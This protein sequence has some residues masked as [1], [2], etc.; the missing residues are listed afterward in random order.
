MNPSRQWL[1]AAAVLAAPVLAEASLTWEANT[2]RGLS[3]FEGLEQ[4]PGL[5][6]IV[7]DPKGQY[8]QVY[9]YNIWD[10]ADGSKD[11]CESRGHK[12]TDGTNMQLTRGNTYYI[13]WRSLW[14]GNVGTQSGKWVAVWQMHAYGGVGMGA[15]FVFRTLGDGILHLQ[16]NVVGTDIHIWNTPMVRNVWHRF[17]LHTHLDPSASVG[18]VELW[19]DGVQQKF[20]N[21]E[22]RYYCPTHEDDAGT[23][24]KL[25]WGIYRT[26]SAT[27]NWHAWMSRARIGTTFADVDPDGGSGPT[28]TPTATPTATATPRATPTATATPGGLAGYYRITARHSGKAVAVQSAS[29]SD[30]ANVFQWTYG[31]ANT[32]DEWEVRGIGSGYYRVINRNSGKDMVVQSAST[33][34]GANIFQWTYGGSSTNDEWA[35]VDVGGGYFRITNR[36]SGKSA[37]VAGGG[38]TDGTNVD[39]RTYSGATYQQFQLVAV[40]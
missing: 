23:Y 21:G 40:P 15:P 12:L 6:D 29:T 14:D 8:G 39:Q 19:Y 10:N 1:L 4:S 35:I 30:G 27:G 20:I 13:G 26:G 18:W 37:E 2:S 38:T 7:N 3:V 34:D 17:V 25:K 28:P 33:S 32:N 9:H 22:T 31:G 24:N 5:I 36:N 16:N 11:R